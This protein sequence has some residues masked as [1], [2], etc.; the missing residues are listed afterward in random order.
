VLTNHTNF[1]TVIAFKT[2]IKSP[3]FYLVKGIVSRDWAKLQMVLLDRSEVRIIP[4][5]VY[6]FFI[7]LLIYLKFK[8]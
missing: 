8:K 6:F 4:L 1:H 2:S 5:D 3:G 7:K